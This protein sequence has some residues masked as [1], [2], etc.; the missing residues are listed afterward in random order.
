MEQSPE[1]GITQP[2]FE[3]SGL[4]RISHLSPHP[5]GFIFQTRNVFPLHTDID[6]T[7][8]PLP[9]PKVTGDE[10]SLRQKA[11]T[12]M[13]N[14]VDTALEKVGI[15]N[16]QKLT[17]QQ[18]HERVKQLTPQQRADYLQAI[19]S[20]RKAGFRDIEVSDNTIT[21]DVKSPF[22]R[23]YRVFDNPS[24]PKEALEFANPAAVAM[25]VITADNKLILQHRAPFSENPQTGKTTGNF[26]YGGIPGASAAGHFDAPKG[27]KG[28]GKPG[29]VTTET[30]AAMA[31]KEAREEIGLTS[32]D[33]A[34]VAIAGLAE[35]LIKKHDELLLVA[36]SN[37]TLSQIK[38][39]KI[40]EETATSEYDF[41]EKF[42]AIDATPE[43][44]ES[45]LTR[46]QCPL[47]P[48]HLAAFFAAGYNIA[49][50]KYGQEKANIWRK[51]VQRSVEEN[52]RQIDARVIA[53]WQE[54]PGKATVHPSK[55][56]V[57]NIFGYDPAY[58]PEE[59][60]LPSLQSELERTELMEKHIPEVLLL[61]IDGV[62]T[63][64][65][66]KRITN[67]KLLD[68]FILRLQAREVVG[69][70]TGRSLEWMMQEV[71]DP[72]ERKLVGQ[73]LPRELL[74]NVIAI[75]EKGGAW[76]TYS[77]DGTR[78]EYIDQTIRIPEDLQ[79]QIRD[80][81]KNGYDDPQTNIHTDFTT[82]FDDI[83][84]QTMFSIEMHKGLSH[85]AESPFKQQ[86]AV[87]KK[88][89]EEILSRHPRGSEFRV[90]A[91]TIATDI[92]NN[93]VGK[94]FGTHT[95]LDILG[96][97]KISVGQ[98]IA[99]GDSESDISM[100]QELAQQNQNVT[101]VYVGKG[102]PWEGKTLPFPLDTTHAEEFENGA[103]AYIESLKKE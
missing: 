75:G 61:D 21:T 7:H 8:F 79:R 57:H 70:N 28:T 81:L 47:P 88:A 44:I 77:L 13:R 71:L 50:E 42:F 89:V 22:Y 96:D 9:S 20:T 84:K 19:L 14:E 74:R 100:A 15:E 37:K 49:I 51:K 92:E 69:F 38:E 82:M 62:V 99:F 29:K 48:T 11:R 24:F 93:H 12:E 98:F 31:L 5:Q 59:Q 6:R 91:T 95:F 35:D 60:G 16:P 97:R 94:G 101:F 10:T 43:S 32:D 102:N 67:E 45:L 34:S 73:N 55:R 87:L 40:P 86:Q 68:E 2:A 78:E 53:Y 66:E 23:M 65:S 30:V 4:V 54:Y 39:N 56:P 18:L 17:P 80:L 25:V 58:A 103:A 72:L 46:V 33:V 41:S 76:I 63:N 1:K 52:Y 85:E 26:F 36:R 27:D 83:T 64:P 90:D 3:V